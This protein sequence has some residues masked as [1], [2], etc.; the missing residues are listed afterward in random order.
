[1]VIKEIQEYAQIRAKARAYLC[2]LMNRHLSNVGLTASNLEE[3][4]E[5]QLHKLKGAIP[6]AEVLFAID[7]NGLQI[8]D[9]VSKHNK[10]AGKRKGIDRSDRAYFY[11]TLK[12]R[13][14]VLTD[15]YPSL[16]TN[17]L[18]VTASFPMYDDNN[19]LLYILCVDIT[20]SKILRMIH[21]SSVDSNFGI[22]SKFVYTGFSIALALVSLL[23]FVKGISG[24]VGLGLN[25]NTIDI[26]EMFKATILL[27]LALAIFDLVKAIFEEEVLGKEKKEGDGD[28]HQTMIR[29]LGS[30][31]IALSIEALMLVF[32]FAITKP[33]KLTSAVDLI[34]GVTALMIGLSV[35]IYVNKSKQK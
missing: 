29:F 16:E 21:P 20:L 26:N 8:A 3:H 18:V 10:L 31:I 32:K 25:I 28:G 27:T 35:Y 9:N 13:R 1:M 12:E 19:N 4:I 15:P 6:H 17:H 30:I 23:L 33:E 24:F 7:A 2:Y 11:K 5:K 22:Y 14:C 34:Y